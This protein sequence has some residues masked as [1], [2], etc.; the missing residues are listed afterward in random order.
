MS[1]VAIAAPA[2]APTQALVLRLAGSESRRLLRHPVMLGGFALWVVLT[3]DTFLRGDIRVVQASELLG[4]LAFFPGIPALVASHMVATRD[5]RAGTLDLLGTTPARSEER[6][7][8]LCLAAFAPATAAL[9]LNTALFAALLTTGA[10]AETPTV[11]HVAQGPLAVLGACLLGTMV[12]VWAPSAV[13]PVLTMVVMVGVHVAVA[14][15]N[16]A[17]LFAPLVMWADWGPYDGSVWFD[18]HPGSPAGHI[19]YMVGLCGMAAAAAVVR[20]AE[21]RRTVVLLGLCAVA[22]TA[23]GAVLQL[24]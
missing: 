4:M 8:A 11:W 9:V 2:V 23:V 13:A 24:P 12:G 10:F 18:W 7:R 6:V 22:V 20:V 1:A 3:A 19:V 14:E 21:R 15:R 5:R 16:P 17:Q